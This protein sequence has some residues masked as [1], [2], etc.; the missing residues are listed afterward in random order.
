MNKRPH[1]KATLTY[2]STEDGG[3]LTPVSSG[4]RTSIKFLYDHKEYIAN[5]TFL[6]TELVFPRDIVSADIILLDP[7]ENLERISLSNG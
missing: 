2:F 4:F 3:I 7:G 1:F 6:E 5:Q